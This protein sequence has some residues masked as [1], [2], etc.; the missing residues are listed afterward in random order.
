CVRD[1]VLA[2]L[3]SRYADRELPASVADAE[4]GVATTRSAEVFEPAA[5]AS[6]EPSAT[7]DRTFDTHE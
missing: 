2:S 7:T 3:R 4:Y 6:S 1:A 5:A